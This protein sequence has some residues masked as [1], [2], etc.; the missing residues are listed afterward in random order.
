MDETLKGESVTPILYERGDYLN[1]FVAYTPRLYDPRATNQN[2]DITVDNAKMV[3]HEWPT[4]CKL[5]VQSCRDGEAYA[6]GTR[7][8]TRAAIVKSLVSY[9]KADRGV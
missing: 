8:T 9:Q 5:K 1:F 6:N 3:D 4:M 7:S 2:C